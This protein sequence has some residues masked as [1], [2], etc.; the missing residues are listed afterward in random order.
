MHTFVIIIFNEL[1]V[2][3]S[4]F[5]IFENK[6]CI[7]FI[8]MQEYINQLIGDIRAAGWNMRP[9]NEIWGNADPEDEVELEDMSYVEKYMYGEE[10][11]ISE[12]TGIDAIMFPPPEKLTDAQKTLLSVEL[13][14]LLLNYSFVLDFPEAYPSHLRYPFIRNF[15]SESHVPLTFGTNHIEFCDYEEGQCPFA[16]YCDIC[17][18]MEEQMKQDEKNNKNSSFDFD[19]DDLLNFE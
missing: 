17:K 18:E 9:P 15:W 11:L 6:H 14:K 12:I 10:E 4:I 13:E 16:G 2:F 1:I 5:V 3:H 19:I 7:Y 8:I